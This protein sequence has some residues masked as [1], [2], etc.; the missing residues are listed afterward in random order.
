MILALSPR[1]S[2]TK[3]MTVQILTASRRFP[4]LFIAAILCWL[5]ASPACAFERG[6]SNIGLTLGSGRAL[7]QT[8]TVIGGRIGYYLADGF[9][10]A[11]AAEAWTDNEPDIL[12]LTPE[13]RYVWFQNRSFKPYAGAFL[14]RTLYDGLPDANTYGAKGGV[15]LQVGPNAH[16]GLG[17]VYE[18]IESCDSATYGD[19]DQIYPEV[20]FS[21]KF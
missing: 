12:K 20:A 17:V 1:E 5:P 13:A 16:V 8:Y 2:T 7:D 6:S 21:V 3:E 19:C 10:V 4:V 18:R 14:S 11:L 9:E 15:Y